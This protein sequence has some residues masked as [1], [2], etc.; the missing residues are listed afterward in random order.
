MDAFHIFY[1]V[2]MVPN[3][4]KHHVGSELVQDETVVRFWKCFT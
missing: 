4:V 3:R 2:K 1:V